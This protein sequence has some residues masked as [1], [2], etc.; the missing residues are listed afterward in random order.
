M[1]MIDTD[2]QKY[3]IIYA[4][5]PW[6]YGDKGFGKRPDSSEKGSFAP[7]NGRYST[8]PIEDICSLN[9][10]DI[11]EKNCALFLWAT[12]PL[13]PEALQVMS[14][15]GFDYR[16]VAFVWSK[17][18]AKG[19]LLH[20]LGQYTMGNTEMCLLGMRGS[21]PRVTRN[22]KQIVIAERTIHSAKPPE[23]RERIHQIFGMV[24]SIELFG[25]QPQEHWDVWGTL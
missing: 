22:V 17:Y 23:I 20:N 13:L 15:W 16:T 11:C 12:S 19:K 3:N 7:E 25:R 2:G 9:V 4:D 1:F 18:S 6:S 8:M 24:P 5:P 21:L 10:P 14:R